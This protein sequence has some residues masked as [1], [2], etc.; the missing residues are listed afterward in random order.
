MDGD[1]GLCVT[2]ESP[3]RPPETVPPQ[4]EVPTTGVI[5]ELA[6]VILSVKVAL[7]V[8]APGTVP[9]VRAAQS[10][11]ALLDAEAAELRRQEE[12][13]D[14]VRVDLIVQ[15]RDQMVTALNDLLSPG[16]A[17]R[18]VEY[19]DDAAGVAHVQQQAM[20]IVRSAFNVLAE[21]HDA[22]QEE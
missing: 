6:D 1:T 5:P 18:W 22:A 20:S 7:A 17:S 3:R 15:A 11:K 19:Q 2:C 16:L 4:I 21:A 8:E 12:L 14:L 10:L 9:H 13:G